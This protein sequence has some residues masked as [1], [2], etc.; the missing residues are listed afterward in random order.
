[1]QVLIKGHLPD[2]GW[3][4]TA[5]WDDSYLKAQAVR[6]SKCETYLGLWYAPNPSRYPTH[7]S[8]LRH[9]PLSPREM[10]N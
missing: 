4:A 7:T 5:K 10:H 9:A 8:T 6:G 3:K 1:M 2:L